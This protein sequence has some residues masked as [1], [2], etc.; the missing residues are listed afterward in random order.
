MGSGPVTRPGVDRVCDAGENIVDPGHGGKSAM[1]AIF[2]SLR[3]AN[4]EDIDAELRRLAEAGVDGLHLDVMDGRFCDEVSLPIDQVRG[5][6]PRTALPFDVHLMVEEP[7][8][9]LGEW[10][11]LGVQRIA[12][13]LEACPDPADLLDRVRAAGVVAGLV[14]LPST[15]T[16]SLD[17]WLDRVDFVN[18]LGVNPVEKTGFEEATYDRIR[19]LKARGVRVQADGG[20]WEQ[21]RD[22]LV[23]AGADELVGGHPIFS[24]EDYSEAVNVL[25]NGSAA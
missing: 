11:D 4:F 25:R 6:R 23:A 8:S 17:P 18:P 1:P 14:I 7:G 20:V 3:S 2:A 24:K 16:S 13:H 15:P 12:F 19:E 5:L 22:G 9:M 10:V 21:T